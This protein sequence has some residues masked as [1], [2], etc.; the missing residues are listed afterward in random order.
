MQFLSWLIGRNITEL[1]QQGREIDQAIARQDDSI[2]AHSTSELERYF[3]QPS[4][5]LPR[6]NGFPVAIV[7]ML[8]LVAFAFNL[9]TFL[10][11]LPP[12]S[13]QM[14]ALSF[15][16]PSIVVIGAML[17]ASYLLA[18]GHTAGVAG[19]AYVC[20]I[21]LISTVLLLI[22]SVVTASHSGLWLLLALA[23]L[24]GARW[25]L[26]GQGFVLFA[27]YCRTQRLTSVARQR[28]MK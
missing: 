19:L 17:T 22:Y 25:V 20:A 6:Q 18:R 5:S 28:R 12:L 3:K 1:L 9:L 16:V 11:A 7:L 24:M 26:N 15:F 21:L 2:L 4:E 8:L 27:I 10:H 13:P 14:H 23:A